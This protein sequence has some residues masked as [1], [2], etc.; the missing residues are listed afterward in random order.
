[1]MEPARSSSIGRAWLVRSRWGVAAAE[2]LGVVAARY[3]LGFDLPVLPLLGLV[4]VVAI[5]NLWIPRLPD[6]PR[7]LGAVLVL[8]TVLLTLLLW[9]SGGPA[10]PFSAL[11]FLHVTLAAILLGGRWAMGV[12]VLGVATYGLLF[13]APP[14]GAGASEA[15]MTHVHGR[16]TVGHGS[17]SSPADAHHAQGR[18]FEAHL[19]GMFLAFVVAGALIAFFVTQI[20]TALRRRE[21]ELVRARELAHAARRLASLTTLAAGAAHELGSPLGTIAV[22]AK[23][24]ERTLL[25]RLD[26]GD[27]LVED[28]QLVRR[29]VARCREILDRMTV[30]GGEAAGEGLEAVSVEALVATLRTR[31]GPR[32]DRLVVDPLPSGTV[33]VPRR[34]WLQALENVA[35]NGLDAGAG[36]VRLTVHRE[37]TRW[38]FELVDEGS[39]MDEETLARAFDPFFSTKEPGEGMG[40]GLFVARAVAAQLGGDLVLRSAPGAGTTARL[41][42]PDRP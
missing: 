8:D 13:I 4:A 10:N 16:P 6:R 40:L 7:V 35:R 29:E 23:E 42:L 5:S 34:A 24:L 31:L 20:A 19:E 28:A 33:R 3:G 17:A 1:M 21:A 2:A 30:Q 26:P 41:T 9:L 15:P 38:I 32:A 14:P 39:G 37:P 11:Y 25:T 27:P 12:L 18:V 36:S 22:V